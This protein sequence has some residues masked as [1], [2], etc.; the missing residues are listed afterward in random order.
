MYVCSFFSVKLRDFI[1][2]MFGKGAEVNVAVCDLESSHSLGQSWSAKI[3]MGVS[4]LLT[5]FRLAWNL[6]KGNGNNSF[7]H[8]PCYLQ[9]SGLTIFTATLSCGQ[10]PWCHRQLFL[11]RLEWLPVP[12]CSRAALELLKRM[13]LLGPSLVAPVCINWGAWGRKTGRLR[14]VWTT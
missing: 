12:L 9:H 4:I 5:S 10:H 2:L 13:I 3:F 14:P 7:P 11:D 1:F 8:T 6:A